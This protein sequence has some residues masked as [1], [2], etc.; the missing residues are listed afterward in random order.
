MKAFMIKEIRFRHVGKPE[1]ILLSFLQNFLQTSEIVYSGE[2][3]M[4]IIKQVV[5]LPDDQTIELGSM[6]KDVNDLN[7]V[8]NAQEEI[9]LN[10]L[11]WME[12]VQNKYD[13]YT[14]LK[15]VKHSYQLIEH[16]FSQQKEKPGF[17]RF[18]EERL[19]PILKLKIGHMEDL[20]EIEHHK[21][22]VRKK[23][24][25]IKNINFTH[26]T[27]DEG[28]KYLKLLKP[29]FLYEEQFL[30]FK[31]T[32]NRKNALPGVQKYLL[33]VKDEIHFFAI[34]KSIS[35][36][37]DSSFFNK[38]FLADWISKHF[39]FT[40]GEGVEIDYKQSTVYRKLKGKLSR[41]ENSK[42]LKSLY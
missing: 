24:T 7:N 1:D 18:C 40:A 2:N 35:A 4:L 32:M 8:L 31:T 21:N 29:L 22:H 25:S 9:F 3:Y 15:C 36:N 39:A 30:D 12:K 27:E 26:F 17:F 23:K 34:W 6:V 37:T 14:L 41:F 38:C 5:I 42:F 16:L 19:L 28:S 10:L 13:F 33:D 20:L 11:G